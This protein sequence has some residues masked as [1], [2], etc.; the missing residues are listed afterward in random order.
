M[1]WGE[2]SNNEV[3]FSFMISLDHIKGMYLDVEAAPEHIG[4]Q[5]KE[6]LFLAE[7]GHSRARYLQL[8]IQVSVN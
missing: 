5:G 7:L 6:L 3:V 8:P 2:P 1:W 4:N